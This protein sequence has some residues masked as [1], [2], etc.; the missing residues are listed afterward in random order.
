MFKLI[1]ITI[2][3]IIMKLSITLFCALIMIGMSHINADRVNIE[4]EYAMVNN[5]TDIF[6]TASASWYYKLNVWRNAYCGPGAYAVSCNLPGSECS[7]IIPG[8]CFDD[9]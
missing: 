9:P 1:Q 5:S 6:P 7:S 8:Q 3:L 2:K 4:Q